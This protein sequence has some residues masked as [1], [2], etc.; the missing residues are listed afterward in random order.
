MTIHSK[1]D[2]KCKYCDTPFVPIPESPNCPK[3]QR[4]SRKVFPNFVK[5]TV[6]SAEFNRW[7][8]RSFMTTWAV[9]NIGDRY[10]MVAFKFLNYVCAQLKARKGKLLSRKFSEAQVDA[11][12]SQFLEMCDFGEQPYWRD[13]FKTYLSLLLTRESKQLIDV[14]N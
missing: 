12:T 1:V 3:C 11:L 2:S 4:K 8:Y 6:R 10:Y 13:G 9:C 5:E 7:K 14:N